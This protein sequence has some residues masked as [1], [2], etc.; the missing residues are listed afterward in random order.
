[1][2]A[3]YIGEGFLYFLAIP[4]A[5]FQCFELLQALPDLLSNFTDFRKF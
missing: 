1:M 3:K 2:L 5:A 4:L